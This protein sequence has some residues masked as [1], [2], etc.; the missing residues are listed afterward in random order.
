MTL[1]DEI[2]AKCP[3]ELVTSKD[4][5]A[6]AALVSVGRTKT[7]ETRIGFGKVLS[8]LGAADGADVLDKLEAATATSKPLKWA[9]KLLSMGDLDIG[10]VQT[11]GQIDALTGTIF[12]PEQAA[13]LKGIAVVA[14]AVVPFDK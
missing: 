5:T 6:I 11:I 3:A 14:D 2:I 1:K 9:F 7:V 8:T 13:L 10:N 12:T 4:Y